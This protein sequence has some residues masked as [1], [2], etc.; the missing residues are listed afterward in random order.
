MT[1]AQKRGMTSK[2]PSALRRIAN[3]NQKYQSSI[4]KD[5]IPNKDLT[6]QF[7]SQTSISH[8]NFSD[9]VE[10]SLMATFLALLKIYHLVNHKYFIF[11]LITSWKRINLLVAQGKMA[12]E[13]ELCSVLNHP[14][15]MSHHSGSSHPSST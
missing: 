9:W 4:T 8:L 3:F 12:C 5:I 13:W 1:K 11:T 14:N 6:A 7:I 15:N 2:R 10:L